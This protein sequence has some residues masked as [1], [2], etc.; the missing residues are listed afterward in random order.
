MPKLS[1]VI[2]IRNRDITPL[3][4]SIN[5]QWAEVIP[6]Y[7]ERGLW[8][9]SRAVNIGIKVSRGRV[10]AKCDADLI[11]LDGFI[12]DVLG[13]GDRFCVAPVKRLGKDVPVG[14]AVDY[15]VW[16][17][18]SARYWPCGGW[19]SAP[20]EFWFDLHGYEEDMILYGA[21]DTDMWNRAEVA[22][23]DREIVT[24][25]IHLWHKTKAR[26]WAFFHAGNA[27]IREY[28]IK[29][30]VRNRTGWGRNKFISPGREL[31]R[32]LLNVT[33]IS[34]NIRDGSV[35]GLN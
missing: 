3:L 4:A 26:K 35:G 20:R 23:L 31:A 11:L 1:I 2:P 16:G 13:A 12:D 17:D 22:G 10:I 24:P 25:A 8:N 19:Q 9:I 29:K 33:K 6:I 32:W 18:L 30:A 34:I 5:S 7:Y 21:E 27:K 14:A 15:P 28:R